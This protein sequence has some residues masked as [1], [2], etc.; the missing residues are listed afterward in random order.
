MEK[1]TCG[2][3]CEYNPLHFGHLH[4]LDALHSLG[5]RVVSVMSGNTVQRGNIA[6]FEKYARASSAVL[7]GADVVV[8]L[9]FP[10]SMTSAPDFARS[11]VH[12]AKSLGVDVLAFGCEDPEKIAPLAKLLGKSETKATLDELMRTKK[13][14]SRSKLAAELVFDELGEEF[15]DAIKKPNNILAVEY[16]IACG[17]TLETLPLQRDF[18]KKSATYLRSLETEKLFES[19]PSIEPDSY[20]DAH[21][22]DNVA[23]AKLRTLSPSS[24]SDVY[25]MSDGTA[26]RLLREAR[27]HRDVEGLARALVCVDHTYSRARRLI[28]NTFFGVTAADV[29]TPPAYTTLLAA[30]QDS[31]AFLKSTSFPVVTKAADKDKLSSEALAQFERSCLADGVIELAMK[32]RHDAYP[33]KLSPRIV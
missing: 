2:V 12:I 11:G 1:K 17:D 4:Q 18:T 14:A 23:L 8:E 5:Y 20:I 33:M 9:P 21:E 3:I 10:Y 16:T 27:A 15:S 19:I 29:H 25:D 22:L 13:N 24:I 6:L 31:T 26:H 30:R 7:H 28:M 32:K